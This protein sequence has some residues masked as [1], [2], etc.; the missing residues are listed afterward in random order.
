MFRFS[1]ALLSFVHFFTVIGVGFLGIILILLGKSDAA[2]IEIAEAL[3]AKNATFIWAGGVFLIVSA[4]LGIGLY[5]MNRMVAFRVHM[6]PLMHEVDTQLIRK[7]VAHFWNQTFPTA[8]AEIDVKIDAKQ[9]I[10]IFAEIEKIPEEE[11]F[12]LENAEVAL[13][14]HL[15]HLLGYKKDYCVTVQFK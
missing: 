15:F 2:R 4:L 13:G 5:A 10:E 1:N 7:S 3:V 14:A 8:P 6:H 12:F 9:K 11:E